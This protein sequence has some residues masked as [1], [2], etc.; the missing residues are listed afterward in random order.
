MVKFKKWAGVILKNDGEVLLCKRS[1]DKSMPNTWSIP[2]GHIEENESP[3]AA[4]LREFYEE[5]NIELDKDLDFVGFLTKFKKDGTKKG[6]MFV[7]L[8]ET[9]DRIEP[10]LKNAKDGWE[11]TSCKYFKK[12]DLPEQKGNEELLE[13]LKR[14]I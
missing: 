11:H 2:S 1:P 4:A 14:I 7:F 8:S 9:K 10:D 3:G 13:I 12:E 6:H 5:T